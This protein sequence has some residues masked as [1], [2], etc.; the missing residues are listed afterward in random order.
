M[1][2]WV[3][4]RYVEDSAAVV[5]ITDRGFL[6]ADAVFETARLCDGGY[7]R[8]QR[9]LERLEQSA[10][11][12]RIPLPPRAQLAGIAFEL[13]QRNDLRD[14]ALRLTATRGSAGAGDGAFIVATVTAMSR[15]WAE[16]AARGWTLITARTRTPP[17]ESVPP[18]LKT[19]GRPY[20]LLARHEAADAGVD[21]V[22]LLTAAGLVAEGPTWNVFWRRGDTLFTP[23][24]AA[25]VLA[26]ITRAEILQLAPG[27]GLRT[28]EGF[29]HRAALDQADEI[30]ATMS[31]LGVV[32]IRSLDDRR[33]A[34][35]TAAPRLQAAYWERVAAAV[36]RPEGTVRA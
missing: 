28:E 32:P 13:A 11:L 6:F 5:P 9:H 1:I 18:A 24:L 19:P 23:A 12:L 4:G 21:D 14:G 8:L 20:A 2:A 36:E 22:L 31:S 7:F 10:A 26:G 33:L 25:G 35:P 16:R 27:L 3:N 30:I 34:P 29:Y 15:D 17:A